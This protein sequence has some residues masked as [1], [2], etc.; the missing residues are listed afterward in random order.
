MSDTIR[1]L[2]RGLRVLEILRT[3]ATS[4]L[5][6]LHEKTRIPKPSLL[7]ILATLDEHGFVSRRLADGR[8]RYSDF[9]ATGR[10]RDRHDRLVE[11][12]VPIIDHLCQKVLWPSDLMVP[13]GD[14]MER[15]ETSQAYS[16]FFPSRTYR[17]RIGQPVGWLLTGVGRAYLAYC[18]AVEKESILRRL[19]ASKKPEDQLAQFPKRLEQILLETRARGYAIRDPAFTGGGYGGLPH[20]DGLAS[21][22]VPLRGRRRVYGSLNI[23]WIRSAFTVDQFAAR[24]LTDLQQAA[25]EIVQALYRDPS[26]A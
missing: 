14:H 20:D 26:R 7:R 16:P 11:A 25:C 5:Q 22:A 19:R 10:K 15:R 2:E 21:I 1:S 17:N 12:A 8:Y 3:T 24:H 18:P 4:S 6:E 23:L 9:R 13:A